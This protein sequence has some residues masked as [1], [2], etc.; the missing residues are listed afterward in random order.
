MENPR[1]RGLS[2]GGGGGSRTFIILVYMYL[3]YF[4]QNVEIFGNNCF[5]SLYIFILFIL[6]LVGFWFIVWMEVWTPEVG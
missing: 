1:E 4:V 2:I 5:N 6:N 3:E